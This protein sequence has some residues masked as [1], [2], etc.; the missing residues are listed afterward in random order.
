MRLEGTHL[1][2]APRAAV[3]EALMDPA[4]ISSAL[5][6]G[7]AM[8]QVG[9]NAYKATMNVKIGSV[10]GRFEGNIALLDIVAGERYTMKV[11][12]QGAPGFVQGEGLLTLTDGE[13]GSTL[14][15]YA[16]DVHVGGKVA[17]VGQRLV[18]STAKSVIRQGLIALDG[19]IR[20]RIAP[21]A[22]AATG[23]AETAA[24]AP[25]VVSPAAAAPT[26]AAAPTM[27]PVNSPRPA[28]PAPQINTG[29]VAA[30]VVKD[31][32]RDLAADYI[33]PDKQE[34][35]LFFGLGALAMLLFVV[36]VRLVQKD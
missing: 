16:G 7:E 36:L 32:I 3:W 25:A 26:P 5:P 14:L 28:T 1:F 33:P 19:L 22:P 21:P 23:P 15:S 8:E 4:V 9:D 35:V 11:D 10:Q 24:V 13:T 31:V 30:N 2:V 12:G 18:E 20:A 17:S 6:G 27:A 34:R 29:Q